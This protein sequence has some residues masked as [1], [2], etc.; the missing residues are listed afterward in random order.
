MLFSVSELL[1]L[2]CLQRQLFPKE[3]HHWDP[4]TMK[5]KKG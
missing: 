5:I 4:E 1:H 2:P 3:D